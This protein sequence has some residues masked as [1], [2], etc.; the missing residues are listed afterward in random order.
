[1][2]KPVWSLVIIVV[3]VCLAALVSFQM[4]EGDTAVSVS[5]DELPVQDVVTEL[6]E[7]TCNDAGGTW[8]TCGSACRTEPDAACIELCVEYCECEGDHHCPESH[9][10][11]EFVED[12]G[13]CKIF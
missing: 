7:V 12:V 8:D 10:C 3:I 13:V 9:K 4:M 6:T 1:M 2:K 11:D 5:V